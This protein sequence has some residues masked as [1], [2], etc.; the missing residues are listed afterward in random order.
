MLVLSYPTKDIKTAM[1]QSFLRVFRGL[2]M[3]TVL[4]LAVFNASAQQ[5][6]INPTGGGADGNLKIVLTP[7]GTN[8][9]FQVYRN[10]KV[11]TA[12]DLNSPFTLGIQQYLRFYTKTSNYSDTLPFKLDKILP[13]IGDGSAAKPFQVY[14]YSHVD[15]LRAGVTYKVV[16]RQVF[17][18]V[19]GKKYFDVRYTTYAKG[20][21]GASTYLFLSEY[22]T[23]QDDPVTSNVYNNMN[24]TGYADKTTGAT[25]VGMARNAADG[26]TWPLSNSGNF[27]K[28]IRIADTTFGSYTASYSYNRMSFKLGSSTNL[29]GIIAYN[30]DGQYK[31][32]GVSVALPATGA[33]PGYSVGTVLRFGYDNVNDPSLSTTATDPM[34]VDT[35][36]TNNYNGNTE[37]TVNFAAAAQSGLEGNTT[38]PVQGL[39]LTISGG[40][41]KQPVYLPFR[42]NPAAGGEAHP[43]V[44]GTDYD[45]DHFGIWIPAN[46]YSKTART[47]DFPGLTIK[48]NTKLE[49]DRTINLELLP[50][51]DNLV[52]LGTQTTT[53]YTIVDD[54]P[55][56]IS[57]DAATATVDEQT[58]HIIHVKL[59]DGVLP[60]EPITVSAA[61]LPDPGN[62]AI[63]GLDFDP[64]QSAIIPITANGTD[65]SMVI[66]KD[67]VLENDEPVTIQFT[68]VVMGKTKT[69]NQ[70]VTIKDKTR[71]DPNNLK[72]S[73]TPDPAAVLNEGYE[74]DL[75]V[76]L[77]PGVTTDN[78]I[79]V[80]LT[81][82][83]TATNPDDYTL[84]TPVTIGSNGTGT[85][86]LHLL[87][88]NL[89]EGDETII[90][91]GSATDGITNTF[92]ITPNTL[93]IKDASYPL[94]T[95]VI[96]HCDSTAITEGG[97][98]GA[99]FWIELP[100]SLVAGKSFTFN[101]NGTVGTPNDATRYTLPAQV[102]IPAGATKSDPVYILAP[103][104][105]VLNDNATL[106]V[107]ASCTDNNI[108]SSTNVKINILD[109]TRGTSPNS[110]TITVTPGQSILTEGDK[111]S[112]T[113]SLPQNITSATDITVRLK[114]N[115]AACTVGTLDYTLTDSVFVIPAHTNGTIT[116]VIF[117]AETDQILEGTEVMAMSVDAGTGFT[118]SNIALNILDATRNNT[119]NLKL[120]FVTPDPTLLVEGYNTTIALAL[121]DGITTEIPLNVTV[122]TGGTAT[123]SDD[124]TL[125][126]TTVSFT[127]HS[128]DLTLKTI[129]DGLIEGDETIILNA[130]VHD[131]TSSAFSV[132]TATMVLK[133]GD[134]PPSG[135]LILHLDKTSVKE[136][137]A[138]G[139]GFW[140]EL[141][142]GLA[143]GKALDFSLTGSVGTP[144]DPTRYVLPTTITIPANA[145]QS[146][147]I[148]ISANS[149]LMLND[150]VTLTI[151]A[152][153]TTDA[154]IKAGNSA[155]LLIQDD[156][157]TTAPGS[158]KITVT[159]GSSTLA[160]NQSTY[161]TI[162]LPANVKSATPI[163]IN[164]HRDDQNSTVAHSDD[165]VL[166][167]STFVLPAQTSS[168]T[169][170]NIF[171]ASQ[172][173]IL[174][175]TEVL[176]TN[177]TGTGVTADPFT[178]SITDET[179]KNTNY[180]K[181]DFTTD[182]ADQLIEGYSG[183]VTVSLPA[184]VTTQVPITVTLKP[185]TGT[186]TV[187]SDYTLTPATVTITDHAAT[188]DMYLVPDG[189]M[190]GPETIVLD[191]TAVDGLAQSFTVDPKTITI[192]DADYPPAH[193]LVLHLDNTSVKEGDA[194]GVGFWVELPD[195]IV[196]QN[197]LVF[198]LSGSVGTPDDATRYVLPASISIPAMGKQSAKVFIKAPANLIL[199]DDV[200]LTIKAV[201]TSDA[202]IK[203]GT[204]AALQILD[205]TRTTTP[206]S[207]KVTVTPVSSTVAEASQTAFTISLPA[208]VKSATPITVKL[209]RDDVNSTL[210][211]ENDYV[212]ND[213][214]FV[215]PAMSQ[216]ITTAANTF[217]ASTDMILEATEKLVS[218][219]DAGTNMTADAVTINVTDVTR[220]NSNYTKLTFTTDAAD[221]LVEN[222]TGLV[223][224]SLP[225]G[226]TTEVPIT[227][228][229]KANTGTASAIDYTLLPASLQFTGNS[230][231]FNLSLIKDGIIEGPETVV[232]DA[233]AIDALS[234]VF[235]VTS[236]TF[237][238]IDGD[239][240]PANKIILHLDKNSITEGETPGAAF[241][242]E[243]PDGL[244]TAAAMTFNVNI[245]TT[246]PA[247]SGRATTAATV[248]IPANGKVSNTVYITAGTNL[249]LND[250][251]SATVGISS[252]DPNITVGSP[253]PFTITDNTRVTSPGSNVITIAPAS[254]TIDE[255][256]ATKFTI[257]L[258]AGVTSATAIDIA[259]AAKP[260][261][262]ATTDYSLLKTTISLPAKSNTYT[263]LEDIV[264]AGA[265]DIIENDEALTIAGDA[266]TA[267]SIAD[268]TLTINDLT[269]RKSTNRELT[270][271]PAAKQQLNEGATQDYVYAL[272][273]GVTTEIP[274][275][276]NITTSG[277]AT[278]S[279]TGDYTVPVTV[280]FSS[281]NSVTLTVTTLTDNLVEGTETIK[282]TGATTDATGLTYTTPVVDADIIDQQYPVTLEIT[283]YP[284]N[285]LEGFSS[286][287][288]VKLPNNWI[289]G[290][291]IPVNIIKA[292]TSTLD[293]TCHTTLPA[294]LIIKK[295]A[296]AAVPFT[297]QA[298]R[299][300]ML[301]DGGTIVVQ[302][303]PIDAALTATAATI[304]VQDSTIKRPGSNIIKITSNVSTLT[305]GQSGDIT[306]TLEGNMQ[307]R[308]PIV[309][310]LGRGAA[311]TASIGDLSFATPT[312]TLPA[313]VNTKT[314]T[315]QIKAE[316]DNI[317]EADETYVLTGTS[318]EYSINEVPLTIKDATRNISANLTL[319]VAPDKTSPV[320]EGD[321]MALKVTLPAGITT[322]VPIQVNLTTTGTA[323][324]VD[325]YTLP[326][327]FVYNKDTTIALSIVADD[328]VEGTETLNIGYTATDG[329]S[330]FA[331][332]ATHFD[333]TDLQYP[334][335][336]ILE[337]TPDIINEGNP[338]GALL[339]AKFE[340]NWKAG[341]DYTVTLSRDITSTADTNDYDAL[342]AKITI[343]ALSNKGTASAEV[344]ALSDFILED[345]ELL[346]VNGTTGDVNLPVDATKVTILDRTHDDPN[347]G[348]IKLTP[349][350]PGNLVPEGGSYTVTVSLA[351]NVTSS[352]DIV[353]YLAS[354]SNSTADSTDVN[355]L[356]TTITIPA[357]ST[358]FSFAFSALKDN[359]IE[360]P[361]LY[362]IVAT[363]VG[364][365]GMSSDSLDVTIVDY[366]STVPA[367]LKMR[368]TIDSTSLQK[369]NNSKMTIG[370]VTDSIVAGEDV[371]INLAPAANSEAGAA[372]YSISPS[373]F[374]LPA[375]EHTATYTL[376]ATANNII[377]GDLNLVLAGTY[378]DHYFAYD[379]QP[380]PTVV[381]KDVAAPAVQLLKNKDA[382]EP[383]TVGAYTVKLPQNYTA[384]APVNV[385]LYV[386]SVPGATNIGSV[387][388][389]VT[390][391]V[392]SN[393]ADVQVPV[394]DNH[395]I[396]GDEFLPAALKSATMNRGA[397][398]INFKV[399]TKDTVNLTIHDDES[400][401]TGAK[402][403]AR[404]MMVEKIKDAGEPDIQGQFKIR[405]TDNL[406]SA[407]QPVQVNYTV[408]GNATP[409]VRYKKLSGTT[410]IPAGQNEVIINVDPIDNNIIEG[411]GTISLQL[412]NITSNL[413]NVTWPISAQ[414]P[415]DMIIKDNDT[416][417]INL[418][419]TA[420]KVPEGSPVTYTL[421]S[422]NMAS[423]DVPVRIQVD[424][425]AV[426]TFKAS[427]GTVVPGTVSGNI[428]TV[429]MPAM[430]TDYNF[431]IT[432]SD[433]AINDED[434]FLTTTLLPY[435]G[436]SSTPLYVE[437]SQT[438]ATVV[439][440]DN[441]PL[442]L[443]FSK[444]KYSVK[445]GNLGDTTPLKFIVNLSN[446]SSRAVTINF[447]YEEATEGVSYPFFDF[448]ATPG[449]DFVMKNK[450]IVIPPFE[451]S[452]EFTVSIIGDTTFE[453]NESFVVKMTSASVPTNT[454][455]PT[456]GEPSK[457][458]GII[459]NDDPMCG[460]CDTDGDGLTNA[461]EDI[462]KNG[463]PFDDDTDGDG[464]PN[465]LDLD[466]DGD[467]VPDSVERW[468]TDG[469]Y[470][471]NNG[472]WVRVHPAISPNNDGK[473]ND[474][475]Y[476]ENIEKYPKN[477]VVIFNRWGGVVYRTNNY[478][479]KSNNFD[480]KS[481]TG[482][483]SGSDVPDGSYFYNIRIWVDSK[484]QHVTGFIVI[485]R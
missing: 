403:T 151:K 162:S 424:Q 242:A 221:K 358:D 311:S 376:N 313:G 146:G 337:S 340:N 384:M 12:R 468:T 431:T 310:T 241:Y 342:P 423:I 77:P 257:S 209:S 434:G 239:Y 359:I 148:Y 109:N 95:D 167:D 405:F 232:L 143:T 470:T 123:I 147:I 401:A 203:S 171:T 49:Y 131:T 407:V 254:A 40:N 185:N 7:N 465:F 56:D 223:T 79:T 339:S 104:N 41:L 83:G 159:P 87:P 480:G 300:D 429:M 46:D 348:K 346:I 304:T 30:P 464:I 244:I 396:E 120:H 341:K 264:S 201:C 18:Y 445:E 426:R 414:T 157:R 484:E 461:E 71:D 350:T 215:I 416:M 425:D 64:I 279:A 163:T 393:S 402:A 418:V 73:V 458:L 142:N 118:A 183:K 314:F 294:Q 195:N 351:P 166:T 366:T 371:V 116:P 307:S 11:E 10:N 329:I 24:E 156:T 92:T 179:R 327:S 447:D 70:V 474:R 150:D 460:E 17:S 377:T 103:A 6:V 457:A 191:A 243:L 248:T 303:T 285:I 410:T 172:D 383:A 293:D 96:L 323:T 451:G 57:V 477:E 137:D 13:V 240:P 479:N 455:V 421:H 194:T 381:I 192:I 52:A 90:L 428:L 81:T 196:T 204:T 58:T 263:T 161:F 134:Y 210:A 68:A 388:T 437:G 69:V 101:L 231:T 53:Q 55:S 397:T 467:G 63:Q 34:P 211:H 440:E 78:N 395:V 319:T 218:N 80:T 362:R 411:D 224:V 335:R 272:P 269:R 331:M 260:S 4:L 481:N 198:A 212:L 230:G 208:N 308:S 349:V 122:S 356:P 228:T 370:F 177:V 325:D 67:L 227:V 237:T 271:T 245:A 2:L 1:P 112:F 394:I 430:Q 140:V 91:G 336:I 278:N 164:L 74:G 443:T 238:I 236:N 312:V 37:V 117:T 365:P 48:G 98:V 32:M 415:P 176:Q 283:A 135:D 420:T 124:Y 133:D 450:Q 277:T 345:D 386:G 188:V 292:G 459:L 347:N 270:V 374:K 391:P 45:Y 61:V 94:T 26:A 126:P 286:A 19:L 273:A 214:V 433:D 441:D 114:K 184:G 305:E 253:L 261:A 200:T 485:K 247:Q 102:T 267:Y 363:P 318:G 72:I 105:T 152:T 3:L 99:A 217:V 463:D 406:L 321:A 138:T 413:V 343:P 160:E 154:N 181:L 158:D 222:Y 452:G 255:G 130:A 144:D 378:A 127:G 475:M 168:M 44:E 276:L 471:N 42:V 129:I 5:V 476:I 422:V 265:D 128:T 472:G 47:I 50:S 466:S 93:T 110:N 180:T 444:D 35:S 173:M 368:V 432:A 462:N 149:N 390:I 258:P 9:D 20:N 439:I 27:C 108:P 382:G 106:T 290:N 482:G 100:G 22:T 320:K 274:I 82:T 419:T 360:K 357:G 297:V 119:N 206:G 38:A 385:T 324:N 316:T 235:T 121:P 246:D 145:K 39:K 315:N 281:G 367:N 88:D 287:L 15:Y 155:Q 275:T 446:K 291:D 369:G 330:S 33:T 295:D 309:I 89:I 60:S 21:N 76:S 435:A 259:L 178:I 392:G 85:A 322:E 219:V 456:L 14:V 280:S 296:N 125:T 28:L 306:V 249:V 51:P 364:W 375:G 438:K 197:E 302:G 298:F 182:P 251:I 62:K 427:T 317:L 355:G 478:D 473:G 132:A 199:N 398:V 25:M 380:I 469:R 284:D 189:L 268:A 233:T 115:D 399:D 153:C 328:L 234:Q 289:A 229:L 333:I 299:N 75:T 165:Y 436:T 379:L 454:H 449:E 252:S 205:D 404:E 31:G 86:H 288:S 170:G 8:Y 169:T 453:Q 216:E 65:L 442:V 113:I 354:S 250:D 207:N 136:G 111:T 387:A 334:A 202:N 372:D 174:E 344:K 29:D 220:L 59:P 373:T 36:A 338:I 225:A 352:K 400:D 107:T 282:L 190:E 84:A 332:A 23:L 175:N 417:K 361:E 226:V 256:A 43:A 97:T 326:T 139:A 186:A 213:S 141:P 408:G 448:K 16:I 353:V 389:T 409:D 66:S 262:A 301:G 412:K 54:E 193:D 266:G 483:A 187:T